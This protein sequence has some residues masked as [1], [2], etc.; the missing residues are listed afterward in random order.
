VKLGHLTA[1]GVQGG[2]AVQLLGGIPKDIGRCLEG[3]CQRHVTRAASGR[4]CPWPLGVMAVSPLAAGLAVVWVP[5]VTLGLSAQLVSPPARQGFDTWAS[6]P[7]RGVGRKKVS[8]GGV[9][10]VMEGSMAG[11]HQLASA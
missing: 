7:Q 4:L 5:R 2:N 11:P 6:Q 8:G 9:V 3:L 1:G 10:L